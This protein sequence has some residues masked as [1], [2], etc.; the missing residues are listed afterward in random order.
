MFIFL[1]KLRKRLKT[2]QLE[3]N[4]PNTSTVP[5]MNMQNWA[6]ENNGVITFNNLK[7]RKSDEINQFFNF[8][9]SSNMI[10]SISNQV[11]IEIF[12][13]HRIHMG[14]VWRG[15]LTDLTQP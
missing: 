9:F 12:T 13:C 15:L 14:L 6:I 10:I 8:M 5:Q 11:L 4:L 7:N 1:K 2:F 3:I